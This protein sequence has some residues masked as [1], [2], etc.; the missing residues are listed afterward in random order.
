[1]Q[2]NN[3]PP[4]SEMIISGECVEKMA[5]PK[6][7]VVTPVCENKYEEYMRVDH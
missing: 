7:A 5:L 4:C 1:M 2:R 6:K 3:C